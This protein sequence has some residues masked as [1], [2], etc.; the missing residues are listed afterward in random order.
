MATY[1]VKCKLYTPSCLLSKSI[2]YESFI[3]ACLFKMYRKE[4]LIHQGYLYRLIKSRS[5]TVFEYNATIL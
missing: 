2:P 3:Y 4:I 1:F 5:K